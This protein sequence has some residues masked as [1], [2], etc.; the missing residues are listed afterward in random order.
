MRGVIKAIRR[1]WKGKEYC[2]LHSS[3]SSGCNNT[4]ISRSMR[5][6]NGTSTGN[7]AVV[8]TVIIGGGVMG[9]STACHLAQLREHGGGKSIVVIERDPTYRHSSSCLSAGGIRQQFS[10][11]E[12]IQMGCYGRDFIRNAAINLSTSPPPPPSLMDNN[13]SL[14]DLQFKEYG[15]LFLT[16][17]QSGAQKMAESHEK[18]RSLGCDVELLLPNQLN[19]KFGSWLNVQNNG[20]SIVM[21]S[22]GKSGEGWV[23][24]WLFLK[25]MK[26]KA[27]DLGV[28]FVHGDV[29][30]ATLAHP[31]NGIFTSIQVQLKPHNVIQTYNINNVVNAAGPQ[32]SKVLDLL[33]GKSKASY[34]P[35]PVRQKKRCIFYFHCSGTTSSPSSQFSIPPYNAPLTIDASTNVYFRPEGSP[36]S[37]TFICGVSPP[38]NADPDCDNYDALEVVQ[39]E[40]FDDIIWPVLYQH[41]PAFGEIKVKSSWAGF[42]E[43]NTVDQNAIIGYH[44]SFQNLL[45]INGFSGHGLM[46][47]PAAG[48][49]VAELIDNNGKF[50]T[51]D[52]SIFS[53]ERLLPGGTPVP[54]EGIV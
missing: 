37:N 54:E 24:P 38:S 28:T 42:Y 53:F 11:L 31:N 43:Y 6:Y 32:A 35:I 15:Y 23:D 47:S 4:S 17:T 12:N 5:G 44:P 33:V 19:D 52:L 39:H 22:Y 10:L 13:V 25:A 20:N 21:G 2:Y 14:V 48:R 9:C 46:Q 45:L 30:G 50:Q 49:A 18:Q 27:I 51:L 16:N 8:D 41:V 7:D 26:D 34:H 3:S 40:L 36:D 29:V 1:W